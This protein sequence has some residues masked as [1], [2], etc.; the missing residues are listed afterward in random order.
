MSSHWKYYCVI[1]NCWEKVGKNCHKEKFSAQRLHL[2]LVDYSIKPSL[3]T[4]AQLMLYIEKIVIFFQKLIYFLFCP[5][6]NTHVYL[7]FVVKVSTYKITCI[8]IKRQCVTSTEILI[9][10]QRK[11]R[12]LGGGPVFFFFLKRCH[13]S[14]TLSAPA[15]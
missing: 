5:R 11:H 8:F 2:L 3:G 6:N 4:W 15:S 7:P 13:I 10:G 9:T 1:Q 14:L 12:G